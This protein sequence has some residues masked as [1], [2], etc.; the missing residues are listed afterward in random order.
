MKLTINNR[1]LVPWSKNPNLRK[2][3]EVY[4]AVDVGLK[5][6]Q[7]STSTTPAFQEFAILCL[8]SQTAINNLQE[9]PKDFA[10]RIA[11]PEF[12]NFIFIED[13]LFGRGD[14]LV[15]THSTNFFDVFQKNQDNFYYSFTTQWENAHRLL[16]ILLETQK[17]LPQFT[18]S[19]EMEDLNMSL[20][21]FTDIKELVSKVRNP[22]TSKLVMKDCVAQILVMKDL[23]DSKHDSLEYISV[24]KMLQQSIFES[25]AKYTRYA[26]EQEYKDFAQ[27]N[28][29]MFKFQQIR[30]GFAH[31][32]SLLE[33]ID[34]FVEV[35]SYQLED[36]NI[37][38]IL[39]SIASAT[40]LKLKSI[41]NIPE[42]DRQQGQVKTIIQGKKKATK[43][44]REKDRDKFLDEVLKENQ[45][46]ISKKLYSAGELEIISKNILELAFRYYVE[47]L[48]TDY[49]VIEDKPVALSKINQ[50]TEILKRFGI[51]FDFQDQ[52]N[53]MSCIDTILRHD[54]FDPKTQLFVIERE[55]SP[56]CNYIKGI[57]EK[58]RK[59]Q[60]NDQ[61]I[62][63]T[64]LDAI[65]YANIDAKAEIF[66][67]A[68]DKGLDAESVYRFL[69]D[70]WLSGYS[71]NPNP[72]SSL[73]L[74]TTILDLIEYI[75]LIDES[76][77][78]QIYKAISI[79]YNMMIT[80]GNTRVAGEF[81]KFLSAIDLI[82]SQHQEGQDR[83]VSD[84]HTMLDLCHEYKF[85]VNLNEV[86]ELGIFSEAMQ[87]YGPRF[88][89]SVSDLVGLI[90][91]VDD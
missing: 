62:S 60:N 39:K 79:E 86:P 80:F 19:G 38:K 89:N 55:I 49:K 73:C 91:A 64:G 12:F 69:G 65:N 9:L 24:F 84:I 13:G 32:H 7:S 22:L 81:R 78:E 21:K 59:I 52:N 71:I 17:C 58:G 37:S 41:K 90:G 33:G 40:R 83:F 46:K 4:I 14:R 6:V 35:I 87:N 53:Q 45:E 72:I 85:G 26:T 43:I 56:G 5:L 29:G 44:K 11:Y 20:Q 51:V 25:L 50:I 70:A 63:K 74:K 75:F 67:K 57:Y 16:K 47:Y 76:M 1:S 54:M 42:I 3:Q 31:S 27:T 88:S 28:L 61:R 18:Y 77:I 66:K 48:R 2:L 68:F 30:N 82:K 8:A 15:T 34:V 23:L 36:Q 10:L